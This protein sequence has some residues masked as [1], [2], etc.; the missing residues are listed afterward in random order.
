MTPYKQPIQLWYEPRRLEPVEQCT[1]APLRI[2]NNRLH[3]LAE[4]IG[5]RQSGSGGPHDR[6]MIAHGEPAKRF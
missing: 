1:T 3:H 4:F 2:A 6:R 5:K